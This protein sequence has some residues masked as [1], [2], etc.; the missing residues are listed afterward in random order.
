MAMLIPKI[1]IKQK[2]RLA[3]LQGVD[4]GDSLM[5]SPVLWKFPGRLD[6]RN[7]Y[8]QLRQRG[9][10]SRPPETSWRSGVT[11]KSEHEPMMKPV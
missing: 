3:V 6:R 10:I 11:V 5:L 7:D 2:I 9:V 8:A 4:Q 1:L